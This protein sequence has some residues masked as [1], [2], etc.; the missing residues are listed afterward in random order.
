[1]RPTTAAGG[2]AGAANAC[3][4]AANTFS[5][6]SWSV[7]R[8]SFQLAMGPPWRRL[9]EWSG[10]RLRVAHFGRRAMLRAPKERPPMTKHECAV[11][12]YVYDPEVGDDEQGIPPGTP[13]ANLPDDWHCPV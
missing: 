12:G 7:V 4:R 1:M 13:F 10:G 5:V 8:S 9:G 6:V 11:C 3:S 2:P